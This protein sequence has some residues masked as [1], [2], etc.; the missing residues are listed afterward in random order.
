M[1]D[2]TIV[3]QASYSLHTQTATIAAI[4]FAGTALATVL[5]LRKAK[6]TRRQTFIILA[7][8]SFIVCLIAGGTALFSKLTTYKLGP[9]TLTDTYLKTP[10]GQTDLDQ[11]A[12]AYIEKDQKRHLISPDRT[13]GGIRLLII[14]EQGGRTHVLSE[15]NYPIEQILQAM[16]ERIIPPEGD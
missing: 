15:E 5:L 1:S 14:L 9:V 6:G 13:T 16:R 10:Y 3:F 2:Q 12:N 8:L 4:L 11:I 7:L